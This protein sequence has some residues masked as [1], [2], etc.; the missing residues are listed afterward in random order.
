VNIVGLATIAATFAS[1]SGFDN[2]TIT[3]Y[4]Y[5]SSTVN[6]NTISTITVGARTT[7]QLSEMCDVLSGCVGFVLSGTNCTFKSAITNGKLDSVA[8]GTNSTYYSKTALSVHP[9]LSYVSTGSEVCINNNIL[10]INTENTGAY[11]INVHLYNK[12]Y[13]DVSLSYITTLIGTYAPIYQGN[14]TIPATDIQKILQPGTQVYIYDSTKLMYSN[15]IPLITSGT[16]VKTP[17]IN[18]ATLYYD[19][20]YYIEIPTSGNENIDNYTYSAFSL[21]TITSTGSVVSEYPYNFKYGYYG[22]IKVDEIPGINAGSIN[23]KLSYGTYY[24]NTF[25]LPVPPT[26]FE[27]S[28]TAYSNFAMLTLD[29]YGLGTS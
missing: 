5:P 18:I 6:S 23:F 2:T 17:V 21:T 14:I 29:G 12:D 11:S 3:Y 16:D 25:N 7:A 27:A 4:K 1:G 9:Y 26:L 28:Y 15:M 13:P 20:D 22:P 19:Y 24:S 10:R 8:S